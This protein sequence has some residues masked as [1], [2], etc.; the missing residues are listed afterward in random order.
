M[1]FSKYASTRLNEHCTSFAGLLAGSLGV[2][3]LQDRLAQQYQP[4]PALGILRAGEK[5]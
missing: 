2:D 1:I 3:M 5:L 4:K